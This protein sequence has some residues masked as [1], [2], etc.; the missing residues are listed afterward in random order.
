MD[1]KLFKRFPV[2]VGL[3]GLCSNRL[4]TTLFPNRPELHFGQGVLHSDLQCFHYHLVDMHKLSPKIQEVMEFQ[5]WLIV[6]LILEKTRLETRLYSSVWIL[7]TNTSRPQFFVDLHTCRTSH[8]EQFLFW[9]Y[10]LTRL[11]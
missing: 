5:K 11:Q 1:F 10:V 2:K 6:K 7:V 9:E 4:I 3:I 8:Q